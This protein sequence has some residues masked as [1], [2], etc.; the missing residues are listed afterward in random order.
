MEGTNELAADLSPAAPDRFIGPGL[1]FLALPNTATQRHRK[2]DRGVSFPWRIH[3]CRFHSI[4]FQYFSVRGHSLATQSNS[5]AQ[6]TIT[7]LLS[8]FPLP[9]FA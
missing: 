5:S 1:F 2:A 7:L 4:A 6:Q 8:S 3:T 9:R